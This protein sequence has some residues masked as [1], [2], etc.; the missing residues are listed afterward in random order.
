MKLFNFLQLYHTL[1]PRTVLQHIIEI[2]IFEHIVVQN[3]RRKINRIS[4]AGMMHIIS[5]KFTTKHNA[6]TVIIDAKY[7]I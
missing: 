5:G 3:Q 2:N 4:D 1:I 6:V 7:T